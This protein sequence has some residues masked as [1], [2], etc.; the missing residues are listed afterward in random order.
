MIYYKEY[1]NHDSFIVGRKNARYDNN[2]YTFDIE[3]TSYFKLN[4]KLY[5]ASYY[6][7][8]TQKEKENCIFHSIMYIWMLSINEIVYYGRT[9]KELKEFLRIINNNISE[10]K[11]LFIH[12]LSWEFQFLRSQFE[13][14]DV[15]ARTK[16]KVMKCDFADYNF[17]CRCTY[18]MSNLALDDLSDTYKLSVKKL[19]GNLDYDIIRVP[20][21]VLTDKEL[22]YCE[23]DCLVVYEYVKMELLTYIQV[24]KI[25]ITSTGKVRRELQKLVYKD[26]NYRKRIRK[27]I[28][29]NP[30]IFN[31]LGECFQGGY[32]HSNVVFTNEII[33]NVDSYDFTSSYPFC[34]TC[35]RYPSSEFIEDDVKS[36]NDMYRLYAYILVVKFYNLECRYFN[37]FISSSK[38]RYIRGAVYDNGRIQRAKEIEIVL[39]D[40]DFRLIL[41]T[42][43]CEYEI[44]ESYASLYNYLPKL[45]INFILDKYVKKTELKNVKGREVEY[46]QQKSLFNSIY[47]MCVTNLIK[48]DVIYDNDTGWEEKEL[49]NEEIIEKLI[50]NKKKGFLA[51]ST[52]VWCTAY[53][54]YNLIVSNLIKLDEY[55][56]YADTDSLKL[57]EG[58]NKDIINEYNNSVINKIKYVSR[59]LNIPIEKYSP[60]DIKGEKHLLGVFE[61]DKK[62]DR[63]ITQGAKKYATEKNGEIEITVAGV[64]KEDGAKCLKNL[65]EFK[66]DFEFKS[67]ITHKQ[68]LIYIDDQDIDILTDYQGNEYINDDSTGCCLIPCSYVLGK[69]YDYINLITEESSKRAIFKE[70]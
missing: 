1:K 12:N 17:E 28:N 13:F 70:D 16:R 46:Q 36:I 60:K 51:Y 66:D 26:Y 54:R 53:A 3:T 41:A 18:M 63:F 32:T 30:H 31:L 9:W 67:S 35:F 55:E 69:S 40:V 62:V 39:T 64:P 44:I 47:G 33:E 49:T 5:N 59:I 27:A 68:T 6:E 38:C 4:D 48:D 15:F 57:R 50:N 43:E 58:Y 20:T 14:K 56:V 65:E 8:L 11:I 19:V 52:G 21:T 23:N 7:K 61:C 2:I 42:Y 45:L 37:T 34:L 25:P 10:K 22:A 24:N 29:T